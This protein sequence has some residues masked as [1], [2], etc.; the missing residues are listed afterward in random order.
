M[1]APRIAYV[2]PTRDRADRLLHTLA[3]LESLPG[4]DA[5]VIIADNASAFPASRVAS[6]VPARLPR[7]FLRQ[8]QNLGAAARNL[9]VQAADRSVEWIVML[10]DDS[11]PRS[12]EFLPRLASQPAD[13]G[14]VMADI[15][16]PRSGTREAGGLPEVFI[17]CGVAI[18]RDAFLHA[19]GYDHAFNY[20]AEEYDLAARLMLNGLRM[21]FEPAFVVDHLKDAGNRD[22][23]TIL[24]RLVRN[25]GWVMQ[26]YAPESE[27]RA[28][29]R[30]I[31]TRYR[32]IA[33]K[34]HA[35]RGFAEGLVEL[36]RTIR[37]QVRR[38][39][40]HAMFDR[41]T[42]LAAA[43]E[44]L[45]A[46][47]RT[48]RFSSVALVAAGK[49]A[50]VVRRALE[51]LGVSIVDESRA[52]RLVVA[53]MSPGPMLDAAL[54]WAADPRVITPWLTAGSMVRGRGPSTRAA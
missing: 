19:G 15:F 33:R 36:R 50:G 3:Q 31:R 29:L 47:H 12:L 46:A 4:H 53:T 18:R 30:E 49:N 51:E 37:S 32:A 23:N 22:M 27:R 16:L 5:Q 1:K 13:V 10:D 14:A 52:E 48:S 39:M 34:E 17:G 54:E 25:N 28:E 9:G 40:H 44:A 21:V 35:M 42:G 45:D 6:E 2:L 20:Y 26:R 38:P 43:R 8:E 24:A 41:F 7:V 11:A